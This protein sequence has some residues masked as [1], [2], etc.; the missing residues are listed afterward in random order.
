[1]GGVPATA[2]NVRREIDVSVLHGGSLTQGGDGASH[3][4]ADSRHSGCRI[5][6]EW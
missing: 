1:M 3:E 6:H 5:P 4:H 2:R